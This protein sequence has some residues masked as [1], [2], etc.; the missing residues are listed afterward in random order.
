MDTVV[1]EFGVFSSATG[2]QFGEVEASPLGGCRLLTEALNQAS[3]E[4]WVLLM[5]RR[6]LAN[7]QDPSVLEVRLTIWFPFTCAS[8]MLS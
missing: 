5:R 7:T 8:D 2:L 4:P 1:H 3:E 6:V